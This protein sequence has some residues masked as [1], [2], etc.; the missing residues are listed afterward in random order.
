MIDSS[1]SGY[2][3]FLLRVA[4]GAMFI[5]QGLILKV[6]EHGVDGTVQFFIGKG[7][8]AVL[9]YVVIAA[10]IGGGLMLILGR[11]VRAVALALVTLMIDATVEHVS[12]GWMFAYP[13]GGYEFP[14]FW[15]VAL[16]VQALLGGGAFAL[17]RVRAPETPRKAAA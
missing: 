13:G 16:V 11:K 9:A 6:L 1:A 2:A 10:E 15:T 12:N 7:Y 3:A 17:D 5:A 14:L 4:M 8:P